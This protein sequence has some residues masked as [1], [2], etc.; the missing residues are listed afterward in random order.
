MPTTRASPLI[1]F[2]KDTAAGA[3]FETL[4]VSRIFAAPYYLHLRTQSSAR[5]ICHKYVEKIFLVV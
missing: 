2:D 4:L 5:Q 3:S 1:G